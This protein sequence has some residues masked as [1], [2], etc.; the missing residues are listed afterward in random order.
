MADVEVAEGTHILSKEI[1]ATNIK[2]FTSARDICNL[3]EGLI[4]F[5]GNNN[6]NL[7]DEQE[8]T[9]SFGYSPQSD[10]GRAILALGSNGESNQTQNAFFDITYKALPSHIENKKGAEVHIQGNNGLSLALTY[11]RAEDTEDES[12]HI[13]SVNGAF[14][15]EDEKLDDSL[16]S[17]KQVMTMM[18]RNKEQESQLYLRALKYQ[19]N[20]RPF[21]DKLSK[22]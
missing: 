12:I 15:I 22:R 7:N 17:I 11:H 20:R 1:K 2:S 6:S 5:A 9:E 19:I 4:A 16:Q 13:E 18:K 14:D 10:T 3:S 8:H 21:L